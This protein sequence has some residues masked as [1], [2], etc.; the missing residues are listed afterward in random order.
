[1]QLALPS[2]PPPL[3]LDALLLE[4]EELLEPDELL[5]LLDVVPAPLEDDDVPVVVP[6]VL[7]GEP[8]EPLVPQLVAMQRASAPGTTARRMSVLMAVRL[9]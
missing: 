5:A 2:F 6:P 7:M 4:V 8:P 3:E 1:M 9:P